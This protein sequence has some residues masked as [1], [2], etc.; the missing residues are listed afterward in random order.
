[1]KILVTGSKGF[2]GSHLIEELSKF[3]EIVTF[4]IK[5]DKNEDVRNLDALIRKS[6]NCDAIVHLAALCLDSESVEKPYDYYTT[7]LLGTL[8][9]LETARKLG[10]KTVINASSAG[11]GD[12][13]PYSISKFHTEKLC[14]SFNKSYG[15]N[16]IILRIFNVYGKRNTKGVIQEFMKRLRENQPITVNNSGKQVRDYI[17]VK[18]VEKTIKNLLEDDY[19]F[20]TYEVGT[21]VG[22]SVNQLVKILTEI[23]GKKPLIKYKKLPYEEIMYSISKKSIVRNPIK[24]EDGLKELLNSI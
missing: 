9:V 23:T 15:L 3:H 8:N 18:D 24:L 14:D 21:G 16:T 20:G 19:A 22:T 4:D 12:R 11:V 7:N 6:K 13:T 10:I 17:H 5:D 2:I 1:M